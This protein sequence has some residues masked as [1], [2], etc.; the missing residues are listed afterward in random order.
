MK[1][2]QDVA[3]AL[4]DIDPEQRKKIEALVRRNIAACHR[5]GFQPDDINRLWLDAIEAVHLGHA[6]E[7][8]KEQRITVNDSGD[9]RRYEQYRMPIDANKK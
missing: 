2:S 6:D 3:N 4:K 7:L 8:L 5:Q 1:I 9:N